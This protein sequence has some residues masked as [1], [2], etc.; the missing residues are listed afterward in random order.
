MKF[1]TG[2]LQYL[3][4]YKHMATLHEI[5]VNSVLTRALGKQ[6]FSDA[7]FISMPSESHIYYQ[8]IIIYSCFRTLSRMSQ[9]MVVSVVYC[10]LVCVL[11]SQAL[12]VKDTT[13]NQLHHQKWHASIIIEKIH[14]FCVNS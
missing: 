5:S 11:I 1:H 14:I 12:L 4:N 6:R 13:N 2:D 8:G 7:G 9:M 10:S 3:D